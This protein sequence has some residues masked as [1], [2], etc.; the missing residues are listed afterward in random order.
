M[1]L[2]GRYLLRLL[3]GVAVVLCLAGGLFA[4]EPSLSSSARIT[5]VTVDGG[6]PLYTAFGHSAIRVED[7][8]NGMDLVFNYGTF[9][10]DEPGFYTNFMQGRMTYYLALSYYSRF[11]YWN[12]EDKRQVS[13]QELQLTAGQRQRLFDFLVW[14][15][16]KENRDYQYNFF[17]DNCATRIRD[18]AEK[19][20]GDTLQF[21]DVPQTA[22]FRDRL[23][24]CL[25]HHPWSE[26][27]IDIIL[28][29]PCDK[30]ASSREIMFLPGCLSEAFAGAKLAGKPLCAP[31]VELNDVSAKTSRPRKVTYP[32]LCMWLLLLL[33]IPVSRS[34]T[35]RPTLD[36]TL[37]SLAGLIG[38]LVAYMWFFSA[39]AAAHQ[40]LNILWALPTHVVMVYF[41]PVHGAVTWE[42]WYF[43]LTAVICL[44]LVLCRWWIPQDL[45]PAVIPLSLL[46]AFR[47]LDYSGWTIPLLSRMRR[48]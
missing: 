35:W 23:H 17:F 8:E 1:S 38:L 9:D 4:S 21:V 12:T 11:L 2:S 22:T 26:L 40:N 29:M 16:Q 37:F 10:F 30:V 34:D 45:H 13:E 5:L 20:L 24:A 47:A 31:P 28:G 48:S 42:K 19:I 7:K 3:L 18:V 41:L 36:R 32:T 27:G 39:H 46:L 25:T 15:V 43:R 6:G 33:A 14:N 44:L